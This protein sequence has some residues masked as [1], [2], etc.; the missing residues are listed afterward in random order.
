MVIPAMT[1]T[2]TTVNFSARLSSC[3]GSSS[4]SRSMSQP[5][6]WSSPLSTQWP[7]R[8]TWSGSSP[9]HPLRRRLRTRR[10][11]SERR[12]SARRSCAAGRAAISGQSSDEIAELVPEFRHG[13]SLKIPPSH[14]D[15]IIRR[16][17]AGESR[18]SIA[19]EYNCCV[20]T[21]SKAVRARLHEL[22]EYDPESF[23]AERRRRRVEGY[24]RMQ[25]IW[26]ANRAEERKLSV[27]AQ[28]QREAAA[29]CQRRMEESDREQRRPQ[30][31]VFRER[32]KAQAFGGQGLPY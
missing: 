9:L 17:R 23:F 22:G 15:E 19:K 32:Q 31:Q 30:M 5:G 10:E 26:A 27:V 6:K 2:R 11:T 24:E 16:R 14:R 8:R 29:E 7:A 13:L 18:K 21:V 20:E 4:R 3:L 12:P 28:E 25:L 1:V